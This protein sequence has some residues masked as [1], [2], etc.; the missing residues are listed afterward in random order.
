MEKC[1]KSVELLIKASADL[2]ARNSQVQTPLMKFAV[3]MDNICETT[4]PDARL[5]VF[6]MVLDHDDNIHAVDIKSRTALH[7]LGLRGDGKQRS[8]RHPCTLEAAGML[9]RAGIPVDA[10]ELDGRTDIDIFLGSND[11][12]MVQLLSEENAINREDLGII[13]G[14]LD[15]KS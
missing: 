15:L 4:T 14:E 9:I 5:E 13:A 10:V 11:L 6:K 1:T 2:A 12:E 3:C 7:L 8:G